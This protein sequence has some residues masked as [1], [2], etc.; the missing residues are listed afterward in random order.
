MAAAE[1]VYYTDE[2]MMLIDDDCI[3]KSP[4]EEKNVQEKE[5]H[6]LLNPGVSLIDSQVMCQVSKKYD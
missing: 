2:E 3:K 4:E 1:V 6:P 5:V